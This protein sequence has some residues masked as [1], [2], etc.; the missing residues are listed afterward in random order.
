MNFIEQARFY[1]KMR[2]EGRSRKEADELL[3]EMK[4]N[5]AV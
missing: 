5:E 4:K 3:R 2:Q 1:I